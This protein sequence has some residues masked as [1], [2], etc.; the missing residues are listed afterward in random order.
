MCENVKIKGA[1]QWYS[2]KNADR[3]NVGH[4]KLIGK[5]VPAWSAWN[6][7]Q[8]PS[9]LSSFS[10]SVLIHFV[11]RSVVGFPLIVEVLKNIILFSRRRK[12]KKKSWKMWA[13]HFYMSIRRIRQATLWCLALVTKE[14]F[15]DKADKKPWEN[16][17]FWISILLGFAKVCY[18]LGPP[19]RDTRR[20]YD[21]R[22]MS[23]IVGKCVGIF[24]IIFAKWLW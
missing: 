14:S 1:E 9:F 6:P 23:E 10:I 7:G 2:S 15:T 19:P 17:T 3:L 8:A 4:G 21:G 12:L 20:F 18:I 16:I 24:S 22:I 11:R 5:R 13:S